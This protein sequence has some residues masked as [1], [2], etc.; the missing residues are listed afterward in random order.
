MLPVKAGMEEVV[1]NTKPV[2]EVRVKK[3]I[4][5]AKYR[6]LNIF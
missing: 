1:A 4:R 6:K 3:V 5:D 2:C